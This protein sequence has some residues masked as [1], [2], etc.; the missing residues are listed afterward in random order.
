[1]SRRVLAA[2]LRAMA[3]SHDAAII[4]A[5]L[6]IRDGDTLPEA[7]L[8]ELWDYRGSLI[9]SWRRLRDEGDHLAGGAA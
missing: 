5:D 3:D 1:M 7:T 8:D 4:D 6:T 2:H 9:G